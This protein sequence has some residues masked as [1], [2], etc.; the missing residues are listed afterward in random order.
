M[1]EHVN[2]AGAMDTEIHDTYVEA[3]TVDQPPMIQSARLEDY[4]PEFG[5]PRPAKARRC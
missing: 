2:G 1:S 3:L 5:R 4:S